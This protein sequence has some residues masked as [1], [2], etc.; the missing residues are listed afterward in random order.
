M[1]RSA[2]FQD[3]L[4]ELRREA[5]FEDDRL[6]NEVLARRFASAAAFVSFERAGTEA[7]R[8]WDR[9]SAFTPYEEETSPQEPLPGP[10]TDDPLAIAREL[11]L[12]PGLSAAELRLARRRFMW[13]HHPDR[14]KD[15][16]AALANRRVAIANMLIDR[17]LS[18]SKRAPDPT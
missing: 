6:A 16:T 15:I 10:A 18:P 4:E 5:E 11:G 7:D 12:A 14:R 9:A 17:A 13:L 1:S 8:L 3:V 2:A